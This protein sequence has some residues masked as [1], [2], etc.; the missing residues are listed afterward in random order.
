MYGEET[1]S[2][3]PD[4]I[5]CECHTVFHS[6]WHIHMGSLN[7]LEVKSRGHFSKVILH[8]FNLEIAGSKTICHIKG[9]NSL[10]IIQLRKAV[11]DDKTSF[12]ISVV[13]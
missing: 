10:M 8:A 13:F 5:L 2:V 3:F 11:K 12:I 9:W 4:F 6:E 7:I 1:K